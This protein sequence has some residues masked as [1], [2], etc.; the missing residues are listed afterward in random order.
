MDTTNFR[1]LTGLYG[2]DANLHLVEHFTLLDNGDMLYDFTVDDPTAW[3]APW[4]GAF[5]W[6]RS[7]DK[8]YEYAC[9]EGNYAMGNTL[10]GARLLEREMIARRGGAQEG[11]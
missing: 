3:T 7:V 8:V 9:H 5:A 6:R 2:G 1:E 11:E 4:S 10:R